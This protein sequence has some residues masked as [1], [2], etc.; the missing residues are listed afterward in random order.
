[1]KIELDKPLVPKKPASSLAR[2]Y[3]LTMFTTI[4]KKL[5]FKVFFILA[6][7][8][9]VAEIIPPRAMFSKKTGGAKKVSGSRVLISLNLVN[10]LSPSI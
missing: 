7:V 1:M 8:Y 5:Q 2:K 10:L 6:H 9:R 3:E 4:C